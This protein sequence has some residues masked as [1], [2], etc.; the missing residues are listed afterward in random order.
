M[1]RSERAMDLYAEGWEAGVE[2]AR[3]II[4]QHLADPAEA[5]SQITDLLIDGQRV[6][7]AERARV[8]REQRRKD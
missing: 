4:R 6:R 2:H 7:A 1:A 3:R 5:L 8:R